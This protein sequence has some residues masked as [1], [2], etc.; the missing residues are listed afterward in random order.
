M[1]ATCA[2]RTAERIAW[3]EVISDA[4]RLRAVLRSGQV[5]LMLL[6]C[7]LVY[8]CV[9]APVYATIQSANK[10]LGH[11]VA[12]GESPIFSYR[13]CDASKIH[14]LSSARLLQGFTTWCLKVTVHSHMSTM[15]AALS[16][17]TLLYKSITCPISSTFLAPVNLIWWHFLALFLFSHALFFS[18]DGLVLTLSRMSRAEEKQ[19]V[20]SFSWT[21]QKSRCNLFTFDSVNQYFSTSRQL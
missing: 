14:F 1:R 3:G 19:Q 21:S 15:C 13:Q 9:H 7:V 17:F 12:R 20:A 11:V 8:S 2:A 6:A 10:M 18:A 16:L 4:L 5:C